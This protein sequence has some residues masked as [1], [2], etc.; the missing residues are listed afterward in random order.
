MKK[1][2]LA[3]SFLTCFAASAS[4]SEE[5]GWYLGASVGQSN[6][7]TFNFSTNTATG[8]SVLGG[9]QVM[10]YFA[11]EVN[12]SD[13]GSPTL[14]GGTSARIDAYG[15]RAV[16]IYPFGNMWSVFGKL[17]YEHTKWGGAVN[18]SRNDLTYGVGAQ[19]NLDPHWGVNV[20]YDVYGV[21]GPAPLN[22]TATTSFWSIGAQYHF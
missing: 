21:R 17:G 3:L 10:K 6:T 20:N 9:Y 1:V 12:W 19:Y 11:A 8:Y 5:Q 14:T 4:A 7:D 18:S 2:L 16:G 13:L 15:A 22:Q